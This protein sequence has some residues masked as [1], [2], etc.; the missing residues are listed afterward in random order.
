MATYKYSEVKPIRI[1]DKVFELKTEEDKKHLNGY[2]FDSLVFRYIIARK[3]MAEYENLK[4]KG[5]CSSKENNF[6]DKQANR[7]IIRFCQILD[8]AI[9]EHD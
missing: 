2:I 1:G 4:F 9:G 5:G 6:Y 3:Q 8:E 7:D